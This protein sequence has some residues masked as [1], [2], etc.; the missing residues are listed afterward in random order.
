M[1]KNMKLGAQLPFAFSAILVILVGVSL[2]SINGLDKGFNNFKNYRGLAKDTNL[3]GRLQANM[4]MVRL[5]VLK[6]IAH[7]SE[8]T[9]SDFEQRKEKMKQFLIQSE[10][11]IQNT[12][13]AE[14]IQ[15]SKVLFSQYEVAFDEVIS[16]IASRHETV[17][18]EL[19]PAGLAMREK[20]TELIELTKKNGQINMMYQAAK[21]QEALLL[22]RL[23]VIKFLVTNEKNDYD[24]AILELENNLEKKLNDL[25]LSDL[26]NHEVSILKQ[27]STAYYTYIIAFK[28]VNKTIGARNELINKKLNTIGPIL[29]DKIESVKLSVKSEQD[30]LGPVAQQNSERSLVLV[31]VFSIIGSVLGIILAMYITRVI[32]SPIG[33]EPADIAKITETIANGDLT[34]KFE[35][36]EKATGIYSSVANMSIKLRSLIGGIVTTGQGIV[37]NAQKSS[38]ISSETS[39]SVQKQKEMTSQVARSINEMSGSLQSVV[40]HATNSAAAAEKAKDLAINGK[41]IVDSTITSIGNLSKKVDNSVDVI[42]SLAQKSNDIGSVVEVIR[43]ISEQTN[44]LALN[45]AIEAA[46]AG[47]QGRGFA[48]VADE[49]RG[50]AQRTRESTN[51]IQEMINMLQ[52]GTAEAVSTMEHSRTET[53]GTVKR[54]MQTGEA[55]DQ[56]LESIVDINDMSLQV[57]ESVKEQSNI[58]GDINNNIVSIEQSAEQTAR[59]ASDSASATQSL[60]DLASE[61]RRLVSGF[62]IS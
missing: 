35:N 8:K 57:A 19:N 18:N 21:A 15:Q 25:K 44:L 37:E 60:V 32:R 17:N 55:L 56:I 30:E 45:A 53:Q 9:L 49:V 58:A 51:E 31:Q 14:N 12:T 36:I 2:I 62:K 59:G 27:I 26:D 7:D 3:A 61:L 23:F 20:M 11:E 48:V 38:V 52:A 13:R 39:E 28:N 46:R 6:Y 41:E 4:L 24:R 54:S 29:A 42:Q 33:G 1:L 22:G 34:A 43:G 5:N 47:E 16:L 50:L 40:T 10:K